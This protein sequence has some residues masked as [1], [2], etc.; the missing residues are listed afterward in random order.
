MCE[1]VSLR[2]ACWLLFHHRVTVT[3]FE[4]TC[5]RA[6]IKVGI[7]SHIQTS[8][9]VALTQDTQPLRPF[10]YFT[11]TP[12]LISRKVSYR[13]SRSDSYRERAGVISLSWLW[14]EHNGSLSVF[15]MDSHLLV[16]VT[17]TRAFI[18]SFTA[19]DTSVYS[20]PFVCHKSSVVF[21]RKA[22]LRLFT[23]ADMMPYETLICGS[24]VSREARRSQY[25]DLRES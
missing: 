22:P 6:E 8:S 10:V 25:N 19:T 20:E 4:P 7:V 1:P 18:V 14:W 21:Q 2:A 16:R 24:S 11:F 12:G 5:K 9:S 15:L 23:D 3:G 17:S 13:D